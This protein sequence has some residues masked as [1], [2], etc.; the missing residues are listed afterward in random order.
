MPAIALARGSAR[1]HRLRQRIIDAPREVCVER[2]RYL[3]ESM[4]Q[5]WREPA[6]TR[7][8]KAFAHILENISV[9][10]RD[11]ELIVGCR[12]SKL[13]GGPLFPENKIG[14]IENDVETFNDRELQRVLITPEQQRELREDILPFW[15][16]KTVQ[17]RF[18]Q[19]APPDV[20]EDMDKYIFTMILEITYGVGHFTMDYERVLA[21][22]LSGVIDRAEQR[23]QDLPADERDGNKGLFY[24]AMIRSCQAVVRFAN[25]YADH[26]EQLA[27]AETD[28]NRAAELQTIA[29]VCRRVPEHPPQTFHEAVQA[30][31]FVHLVAQIESGGNSISPGRID[32]FLNPY[33]RRNADAGTITPDHAEELLSL[34]FL[35]TNEI[36]NILEEAF[37]P[38]GEGTE[39]KTTQNVVVGGVG[40]DG[41]DATNE[42]STIGLDAYAAVQTVQPNFGVR[43]APDTPAD[44]VRRV[45]RYAKDGVLLHLFNDPVIIDSL[46]EAGHTTADARNY[47]VVGCLEP[48]AQGKTFGST[49]AVQFS[50]IKCL[51][52]A[53]S[54]GVDNIFGYASG[55]ET[56]DP[57]DFTSFEDVWTA[58]RAQSAHFMKQMVCGMAALDQAV[59]ELAPSPFASAMI[60]GPLEKGLDV[61]RGG[62]VYNSTGVELIGFSNVV[63]SL[64]AIKKAVFE[65][66]VLS[67][68]D[69]VEHL[70]EDWDDAEEM[71]AYL[72]HKIPKFGNDHDAVDAMGALVVEHFCDEVLAH[73]NFRGGHFWP[74]IFSVGFHVAMGAFAGA[75]PDGR[76]AGDILG[77]GLSPSNGRAIK[78]PTAVFNSVVKLPLERVHNGVNLNM[79]FHGDRLKAETLQSLVQTYFARGGV[80]VQF[81]MVDSDVLRSAQDSP[82]EY[83]DLVVRVSGYSALFTGMSRIAQDEIIA[84]SEY[85]A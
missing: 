46:Q 40:P 76:H 28:A 32:Q 35:K 52:L 72:A 73:E 71:R 30:A 27:A 69:L 78:G 9:T 22:G 81:N 60:D 83:R 64:Y 13:K 18:E 66:G 74:G 82:D 44:F 26:A 58:Y 68:A 39:G 49:F 62:A 43:F 15:R 61:T 24:Q 21:L 1:V 31:Y 3:T 11:D 41:R 67:P 80:Q 53:L 33:Y 75:S 85:E 25:R 19:L 59:A 20:L 50:G 17:D 23:L 51:E 65:D 54:N 16:G 48:N 14:W 2:A 6:L 36:W 37:I 55:P 29:R 56:G 79:R 5:H 10:I 4:K 12:T 84:R 47:G 77:N 57:A 63:D 45:V 38:G 70:A 7:M 34:L 42:L 8:S